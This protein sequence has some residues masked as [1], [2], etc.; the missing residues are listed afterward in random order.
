[1]GLKKVGNH[2]MSVGKRPRLRSVAPRW[3]FI[4]SAKQFPQ[5]QKEAA[6]RDLV[7]SDAFLVLPK[8][9]TSRAT[10]ARVQARVSRGE[11]A[12]GAEGSNEVLSPDIRA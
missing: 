1:M 3:G 2:T 8:T 11:R 4:E 9:T 6:I 10:A 5:R 7:H 12:R